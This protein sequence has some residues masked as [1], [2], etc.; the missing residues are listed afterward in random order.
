LPQL[1]QIEECFQKVLPPLRPGECSSRFFA[2]FWWRRRG[3][4]LLF[5]WCSVVVL[6]LLLLGGT[7]FPLL[8][9]SLTHADCGQD[10]KSGPPPAQQA[11]VVAA[12]PAAK[13]EALSIC[14]VRGRVLTRVVYS[15]ESREGDPSAFAPALFLSLS[16]T[17]P[18][19][20]QIH[21]TNVFQR[22]PVVAKVGEG[23]PPPVPKKKAIAIPVSGLRQVLYV[24]GLMRFLLF[25]LLC[26]VV[27]NSVVAL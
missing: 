10:V 8:F 25:F 5:L 21:L 16:S 12:Q 7:H 9:D 6:L 17:S 1:R 19:S 27:S 22:S 23:P 26:F 14:I 4:F 2:F 3:R 13:G 20:E 15:S 11:A 24:A 18:P